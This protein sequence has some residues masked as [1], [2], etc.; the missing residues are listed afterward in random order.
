M[1]KFNKMIG[2]QFG[3]P[4]GFIGRI[5]CKIMNVINKKMYKS[6]INEIIADSTFDILDIGYGNGY[7]LHKMY[8]KFGCNLKGIEVSP[9][10]EKL[11]F[12]RNKNEIKKGKI[13]LI[14][15]DCCDMPFKSGQFEFVTTVNTIYFWKDTEKGLTEI[16]RVLKDG[17]VFYCAVYSKDWLQKMPYT[18]EG[19]KFFD[20]EDYI[21]L[22][23]M[24]GFSEVK[25]KDIKKNKNFLIE[26]KR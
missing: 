21:R 10:A 4:K 8:K 24:A 9:D 13:E 15:A 2:Q 12:K 5:C 18:Q 14:A 1:N 20:M 6:V 23:Q 19:F 11:A 3:Q 26:F 25:I 16:Q 17:G 22:G 7:L